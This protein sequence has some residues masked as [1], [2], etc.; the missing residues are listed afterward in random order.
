MGW[1]YCVDFEKV[2]SL[3]KFKEMISTEISVTI[4]Y[5]KIIFFMTL[6]W[7]QMSDSDFDQSTDTQLLD[8]N[9]C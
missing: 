1:R 5:Y 3:L 8:L 2:E 4:L 6:L 9:G 7:R